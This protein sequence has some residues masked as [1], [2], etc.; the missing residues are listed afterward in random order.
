M[1]LRKKTM[2]SDREFHTNACKAIKCKERLGREDSPL[3]SGFRV[4][5]CLF[6][7]RRGS[8]THPF[9]Q[10][11]VNTTTSIPARTTLPMAS[12]PLR[13]VRVPLPHIPIPLPIVSPTTS[14]SPMPSLIPLTFP[15]PRSGPRSGP[16]PSPVPTG[17]VRFVFIHLHL[18]VTLGSLA[19]NGIPIVDPV[20][21]G[22]RTW[23]R[24]FA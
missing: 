16:G 20:V 3:N 24:I 11:T 21:M 19:L 23:S 12:A 6:E 7:G 13:P 18:H 4:L 15:V 1:D 10:G 2:R 22:S 17:L 9:R 14:S 5:A 8:E